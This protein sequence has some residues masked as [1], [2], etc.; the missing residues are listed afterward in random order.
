LALRGTCRAAGG[1][2]PPRDAPK[3]H[4]K[5]GSETSGNNSRSA[6]KNTAAVSARQTRSQITSDGAITPATRQHRH[7]LML[8]TAVALQ[9][10]RVT[11]SQKLYLRPPQRPTKPSPRP[12]W[13]CCG[14]MV[15][16]DERLSRSDLTVLRELLKPTRK[17]CPG[18]NRMCGDAARPFAELRASARPCS[19]GLHATALN[20]PQ[21]A[22]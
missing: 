6:R 19:C 5:I 14:P 18:R 12:S 21:I 1:E 2:S 13:K 4:Q 3:C 20:H 7:N 17:E 22:A 9:K 11:A 16:P 15:Q 8:R 10:R